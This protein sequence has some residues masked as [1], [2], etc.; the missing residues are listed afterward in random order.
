MTAVLG[1]DAAWTA[2]NDSGFALIEEISGRWRLIAAASSLRNLAGACDLEPP[3]DCGL[4]FGVVCAKRLLG[5]RLPD[6]IAIDMP[7]SLQPITGRRKSDIAVSSAFGAAKCS[8]H[9]P[10]AERPGK[11][12]Q[13]LHKELKDKG[14]LLKTLTSPAHPLTLAEIYP[15]PALLRLMP[16]KQRVPYKVS[17]TKKYWPDASAEERLQRV[18]EEL[19]KI[20]NRLEAVIAGV[21]PAVDVDQSQ[22]FTALKPVEDMIDAIVSA[23]VG[24][25]ILGGAAQGYG[26]GISTIWI[27]R[28]SWAMKH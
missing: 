15:H 3:K 11:I 12:S 14:Y 9:S 24:T 18:R 22:N 13:P 8:T 23:W 5:G 28:D 27:P 6:V 21:M 25:T 26:D 10:S 1:I 4:G 20:V 7:L 16:A 2:A 19:R 17:K